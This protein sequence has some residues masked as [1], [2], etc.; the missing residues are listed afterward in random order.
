M[1]RHRSK[2]ARFTR[3]RRRS[4]GGNTEQDGAAHDS[5]SGSSRVIPIPTGKR[6]REWEVLGGFMAVS[7][8]PEF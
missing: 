8:L 2:S 1:F 6:R 4:P 3:M 7:L 5:P